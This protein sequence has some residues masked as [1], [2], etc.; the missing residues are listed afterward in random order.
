MYKKL[1]IIFA[2]TGDFT[3]Y[4]L[5]N[6]L[7]NHQIVGILT[8]HDESMTGKKN[9][10][11]L[12]RIKSFTIKHN[13]SLFQPKSE[14]FFQKDFHDQLAFLKADLMVVISYGIILPSSVINIPRLGCINVHSSLLPRWRGAAPIPRS[15]IA[16]DEMTGVTTIQI[17]PGIDTGDILH[18]IPCA[19][20]NSDTSA[21]LGE[22]LSKLGSISMLITLKQCINGNIYPQIQ[23]ENTATYARKIRKKEARINW[24]LSAIEIERHIRAF[25]PW[26][27]SYFYIHEKYIKV[28]KASVCKKKSGINEMKYQPGEI[29]QTNKNGIQIATGKDILNIEELQLAGKKILT[30]GEFINSRKEWFTSGLILD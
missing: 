14:D 9:R 28:W 16:G 26:P 21:T 1:K 30:V 25:N 2:G 3:I 5:T 10:L 23:P 6:L 18:Q 13:I 15:I 17:N 20:E 19:I 24:K 11:L 27:V 7:S 29:I 12:S 22:K 4:H 8:S